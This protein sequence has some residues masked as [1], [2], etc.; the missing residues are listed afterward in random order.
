MVFLGQTYGAENLP[1][2]RS[3]EPIPAGWYTATITESDV[4]QTKAGTGSYIKLRLDVV[5]PTHAGR[6][7]FSN[8]NIRNPN[9]KAEEIGL[10]QLNDIR[11]AI[12]LPS[13]SDSDQLLGHT[14]MVKVDIKKEDGRDPE[15]DVR[16][17][18]SA[19]GGSELPAVSAPK[20][21]ATTSA[22]P[23]WAKK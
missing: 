4:R 12:G 3:Y 6:V 20:P 16:G 14:I 11:L 19:S 15:N 5:G 7:L 9:P 21:A 10:R 18:K 17:F 8:I 2:A 22:A 23:P 1:E 13:I